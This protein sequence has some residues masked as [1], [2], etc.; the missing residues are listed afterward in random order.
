LFFAGAL[1]GSVLSGKVLANNYPLAAWYQLQS[2]NQMLS[3]VDTTTGKGCTNA[4]YH[5]HKF[6][7]QAIQYLERGGIK[8]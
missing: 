7:R 8:P 6:V 4:V 3:G 2:A 1:F 5:A